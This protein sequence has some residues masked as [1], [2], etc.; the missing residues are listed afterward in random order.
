MQQG[1]ILPNR[2]IEN[3]LIRLVYGI[4]NDN[5]IKSLLREGVLSLAKAIN[6][7]QVSGLTKKHSKSL[8]AKSSTLATA[9]IDAVWQNTHCYKIHTHGRRPETRS[10]MKTECQIKNCANCGGNH[11]AKRQAMLQMPK[12]EPFPE[13]LLIFNTKKHEHT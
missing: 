4:I 8:S 12:V 1:E 3:E 11:A 2:T 9:H 13:M 7:C 10:K 5:I 6:I